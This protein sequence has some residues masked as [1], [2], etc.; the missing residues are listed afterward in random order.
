M[1]FPRNITGYTEITK[2]DLDD[3][4][5]NQLNQVLKNSAQGVGVTQ[6][7]ISL[8]QKSLNT[9]T[10]QV[11]ALQAQVEALGQPS[12]KS[13]AAARGVNAKGQAQL[14]LSAVGALKTSAAS[15]ATV[16][17]GGTGVS[18]LASHAVVIGE[19]SAPVVTASPGAAGTV[20]TS[21]GPTSDP[22]FEDAQLTGTTGVGNGASGPLDALAQGSGSGP[23]SD[24][25][26]LW[27]QVKANGT[28]YWIPLFL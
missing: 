22:D 25:V 23:A 3:P 6:E 4:A 7:Q 18:S 17:E 5:L 13:Y 9:L 2:A 21:R 1:D 8:V 10:Q 24:T 15:V 19:G 12:S 20:L 14:S 11:A 16:P 28:S 26:S 27:V